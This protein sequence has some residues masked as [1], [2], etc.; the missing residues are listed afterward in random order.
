MSYQEFLE[1]VRGQL[2][3][4]R[5]RVVRGAFDIIDANGNGQLDIDELK[6][7][8]DASRHPYVLNGDT[9]AQLVTNEFFETFEAHHKMVNDDRRFMPVS[10][11]QFVDYY[12]SLSSLFESDDDFV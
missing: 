3:E 10:V 1:A 8:F 11:E 4:R 7:R 2:N 9:T 6:Q 12:S 5:N